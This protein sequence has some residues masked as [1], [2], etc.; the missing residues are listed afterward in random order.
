MNSGFS[1]HYNSECSWVSEFG[2][3]FSLTKV[4]V[5]MGSDVI[6][7]PFSPYSSNS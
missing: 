3:L 7:F 2:A 6:L 5:E 1:K 4:H